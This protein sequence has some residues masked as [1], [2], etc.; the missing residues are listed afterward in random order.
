MS[1]KETIE[2]V[3]KITYYLSNFSDANKSNNSHQLNAIILALHQVIK[4]LSRELPAYEVTPYGDYDIRK[5]FERAEDNFIHSIHDARE[6]ILTAFVAKF[7][8]HPEECMMI[9]QKSYDGRTQK[10]YIVK[11][12]NVIPKRPKTDQNAACPSNFDDVVMEA[13]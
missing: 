3:S 10:W 9:E 8:L 4:D 11:R 2:R 13:G 5:E 7:Q 6:E 12:D 1:I